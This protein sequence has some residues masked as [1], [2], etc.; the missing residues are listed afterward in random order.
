M[1][2]G[3]SRPTTYNDSVTALQQ[4][5]V[6]LGRNVF[7]TSQTPSR[8]MDPNAMDVDRVDINFK[9]KGKFRSK[10]SKCFRC[11]KP[12]HFA[13]D[14]YVKIE[15]T[16]TI[17]GPPK[18]S[19]NRPVNKGWNKKGKG[20]FKGNFQKKRWIRGAEIEEEDENGQET[21]EEQELDINYVENMKNNVVEMDEQMRQQYLAALVKD[22]R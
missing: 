16:S 17:G 3:F 9:G 22:F 10:D 12:G 11:G 21:E 15:G 18:P 13:K 7:T 19:G 14:C 1:F 4:F 6:E 2:L 8:M 5:E 20:K